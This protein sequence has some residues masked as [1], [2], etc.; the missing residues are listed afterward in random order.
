MSHTALPCWLFV[1]AGLLAE[2]AGPPTALAG[3]VAQTLYSID[4]EPGNNVPFY[5]NDV[6]VGGQAFG[7]V[8]NRA[9]MW[10][11]DGT[12]VDMTPGGLFKSE[13]I[14][15]DGVHQVGAGTALSGG[16]QHALV[17]AGSAASAVDLHPSNLSGFISSVA[18]GVS[19][20][21]Q[22]G[23]AYLVDSPSTGHAMLWNGS[24]G[25]AVDLH[26][27]AFTGSVAQATDSHQ[28]VGEAYNQTGIYP[29][30]M[31]WTGTAASAVDL[32]PTHLSGIAYSDALGVAGGQQVGRGYGPAGANVDAI[33]TH[34][35]LWTG[36]ADTAIDLNPTLPGIQYSEAV[37][38]NG[39]QQ[40]GRGM[41]GA[42]SRAV[43]WSGSADSA[44]DLQSL[45]PSSLVGPY[46]NSWAF[47]ID[48]RGD[49][50][51]TVIPNL[52]INQIHVVEWKAVPEP[53]S[54]L[55][56]FVSIVLLRRR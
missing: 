10:T 31:L 20:N 26:P 36:T 39:S 41:S 37:A 50:F 23:A 7:Y 35:L 2:L 16:P 44:V 49:I 52:N 56:A 15:D 55:V 46:T 42:Y 22:V 32:N 17:W 25:S 14:G 9:L 33:H 3:Y 40:V 6:A 21:Q 1:V 13:V 53:A 34:A 18:A 29:H 48:S 54:A 4:L 28:Q 19:G 5:Y 27:S 30:A 45:L 8:G 38:T 51:G 43:V 47:A 12:L 24:A 11:T